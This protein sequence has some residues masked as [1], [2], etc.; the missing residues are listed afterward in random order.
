MFSLVVAPLL[1]VAGLYIGSYPAE[2][3]DWA[4]WSMQLHRL[5]VDSI[6]IPPESKFP[7]RFS[8]IAVQMC[9]VAIFLSSSLREILS[10]RLLVWLGH[11][12]FAVYLVHGTILRTVGMWIVYGASGDPW[13]PPGTD[14]DGHPTDPVWLRSRGKG[15]IMFAIVVFVALTYLAA[16]AWMRWVDNAC[17]SATE[18]LASKVFDD[19]DKDCLA[20][21]GLANGNGH[22]ARPVADRLL[23]NG[24]D[25]QRPRLPP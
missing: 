2:H 14:E 13:T 25:H 10:H 19:D 18:W 17:K 6:L 11:H 21:K 23:T 15:H 1:I 16:Y 22:A 20:E 12:S 9:A 24:T 7:R 8:T 3:E 4:A 5:L